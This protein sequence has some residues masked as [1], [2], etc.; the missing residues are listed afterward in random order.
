MLALLEPLDLKGMGHNSPAYL[1]AV[2]E[3]IKLAFA[4][5]EAFYGDPRMVDV[6][7][8]RLLDSSFAAARRAL[9]DPR[10]AWPEMPPPG[11]AG[12]PPGRRSPAGPADREIVSRDTSYACVIDRHGN[13]FS[14]TPSDDSSDTPVTPGT[15]MCISSRG[16]QSWGFRGHRSEVAPGKRPR[17]TPNPA[18]AI[19][20]SGQRF[21]PFGTPGGDVQVQ[22]MLQVFLNMRAFGMEIQEAVEAPRVASY[23]FPESFEPHDYRPGL[24]KLE[25][26]LPPATGDALAGLGHRVEYWPDLEQLAGAVCLIDGDRRTGLISGAADPRRPAYALGW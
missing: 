11:D 24:V 3:A 14:G 8:D 10:R 20:P 4:D 13:V 2:L 23:S 19:D 25:D 12:V 16:S 26:R 15:G 21:I 18:L 9:I 22:A 7:M 5:R 6:P 17:L 1:H